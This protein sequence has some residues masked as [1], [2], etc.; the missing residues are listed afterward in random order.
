MSESKDTINVGTW[1]VLWHQSLMISLILTVGLGTS[2]CAGLSGLI[3]HSW[4]EEVLLH[5]GRK[6]V[7]TRSQTYGG[8]H[9]IGQPPPI[10]EHTVTFTLP[11]T[12]KVI[13]WTSEYGKELGRT[14]FHLLAVHVMNGTP[15][16]VA[17][18]NLCL[19]Y[20]K[21]GRPNPPYVF[22]KNDGT[23]WQRIT[24]SDL[25]AEFTTLNVAISLDSG[26]VQ[27]M[28]KHGLVPVEEIRKLNRALSQP[29]YQTLLREPGKSVGSQCGEMIYAGKGGWIGL[30]WFRDQ[31]SRSACNKSCESWHVPADRCP[32][33]T[34]FKEKGE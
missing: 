17:E 6:M 28:V 13:R 3:G 20:N 18:P 29:E 10:K 34:L 2:S 33:A 23:V 24:L 21:W 19:S 25:P 7:I 5:D 14:N 27:K 31:P 30:G 9:E 11:N 4:K 26:I 15:Y 32:C 22:F 12:D 8:S 1:W 16:I